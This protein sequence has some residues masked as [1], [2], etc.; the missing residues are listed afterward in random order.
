MVSRDPN[1]Q[2]IQTLHTNYLRNW[3]NFINCTRLYQPS[4]PEREFTKVNEIPCAGSN[5]HSPPSSNFP[6]KWHEAKW[7]LPLI[8]L[9]H[10]CL[11]PLKNR[12]FAT[13]EKKK[14]EKQQSSPRHPVI[15]SADDWGVQS[16]PKRIVFRFHETILRFDEPGSLGIFQP[17]RNFQKNKLAVT[18]FHYP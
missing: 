6:A 7:H 4:F 11:N 9:N 17:W 12:P 16:P 3:S 14:T 2:Y 13:H 1:C 15:L 8:K 18:S 10:H 5:H